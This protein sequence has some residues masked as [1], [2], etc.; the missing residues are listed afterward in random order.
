MLSYWGDLNKWL[1]VWLAG[2]GRCEYAP[3]L[4]CEESGGGSSIQPMSRSYMKYAFN[5]RLD[6]FRIYVLDS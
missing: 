2:E 5:G 3:I 1:V 6:Q 4:S